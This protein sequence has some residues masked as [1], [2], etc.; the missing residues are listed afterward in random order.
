MT[1][2]LAVALARH[3]PGHRSFVVLTADDWARM[4]D[5]LNAEDDAEDVLSDV[6][7]LP[8]EL[9]ACDCSDGGAG[10]LL[11]WSYG[12][13]DIPDDWT[14]VQRCDQC[15]RFEGDDDAAM[16]AAAAHGNVEVAYWYQ[17]DEDDRPAIV[18]DFCGDYAIRWTP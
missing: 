12:A 18:G 1:D 8:V 15:Q 11:D 13:A 7:L 6:T 14:P 5:R 3:Y 9:D 10:Y 2:D 16:A 4:S 17:L